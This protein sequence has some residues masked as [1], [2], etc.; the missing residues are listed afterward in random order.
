MMKHIMMKEETNI[1]AYAKNVQNIGFI[2]AELYMIILNSA[3][4]KI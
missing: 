4:V 3:I 2:L 1:G